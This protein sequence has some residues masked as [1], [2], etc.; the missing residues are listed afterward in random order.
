MKTLIVYFSY[1]GNTRIISNYINSK[2][3]SDMLEL[4]TLVKYSDDY[5]QV[6]YQGKDE[7]EQEF[8]PRLKVNDLNLQDYDIILLGS[9]IWWYTIAPAVRTFLSENDLSGKKLF[10]FITNGGY[11]LGHSLEDIKTLC[12]CEVGKV[13]EIPFEG[14]YQIK[15]NIEIDDWLKEIEEMK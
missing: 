5:S 1:S 15:D 7:V 10:P 13:L 2:I 11:G 14:H 12:T 8:K 4:E 9:P 6:T 3:N